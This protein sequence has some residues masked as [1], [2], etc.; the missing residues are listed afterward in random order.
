MNG[1]VSPM[2]LCCQGL[3]DSVEHR[4]RSL[5]ACGGCRPL[6]EHL[7]VV[8]WCRAGGSWWVC[9]RSSGASKRG[10]NC[11][12]EVPAGSGRCS[13]SS[14]EMPQRKLDTQR[15]NF[16]LSCVLVSF[17][18]EPVWQDGKHPG[19]NQEV[20]YPAFST[21]PAQRKL[22]VFWSLLKVVYLFY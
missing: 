11:I 16:P 21:K 5:W 8:H 17:R 18:T 7:N 22:I 14:G 10:A 3:E 19:E 13:E 12:R 4:A 1:S 15:R 6:P 9:V 20:S 2:M